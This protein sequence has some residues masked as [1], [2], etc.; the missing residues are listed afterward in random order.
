MSSFTSEIKVGLLTVISLALM[1]WF[2]LS[3]R[4]APFGL[5][6]SYSIYAT[7]PSAEGIQFG[8]AVTMA[9]VKVGRVGTIELTGAGQARI[10]LELDK[11]VA[12]PKDSKMTVKSMGLL[13]DRS[14]H[15]LPGQATD[16]VA[17]GGEIPYTAGETDID[18]LTKKLAGVADEV[19]GITSDLKTISGS[20][21]DTITGGTMTSSL[22]AILKNMEA[23]SASVKNVSGSSQQDIDAIL[24]NIETLTANMNE[25]VKVSK[26]VVSDSGEQ[27]Q[28]KI[29]SVD[30]IVAEVNDVVK[31]LNTIVQKVEKGE[32]TVGALLT[33]ASTY[34]T[35]KETVNTA[36]DMVDKV[37]RFETTVELRGDY[38][39]AAAPA[40]QGQMK[41]TLGVT[42]ATRKDYY[43]L[44]EITSDPV[45]DFTFEETSYYDNTGLQ[46]GTIKKQ[47]FTDAYQYTFQFAKRFQDLVLRIGIKENHGAVGAD[48]F[49]WKDR[50]AFSADLYDFT[51]RDLIN[52]ELPNLELRSRVGL[53]NHMYL[54][55]GFDDVL[56][57][58]QAGGV[59]FYMGA[60]LSFQDADL[61]Y[62][63][64]VLPTP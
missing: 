4:D 50:I 20:L 29:K 18:Q 10:S 63:L 24:R 54:A 2:L 25:L 37:N 33:D 32:G 61:K 44:L 39:M 17:I 41:N 6:Q 8:S 12:L 14:V 40:L 62:L 47:V 59:N 48:Y 34:D 3:T 36:A 26:G 1:T 51:T 35:L 15:L 60:G 55:V 23:V 28:D 45:M 19:Q 38:Y 13:G 64:S 22:E 42:L 52:P 21:K 49:L 16:L 56:N 9:G 27:V 31:N 7:V 30:Q 57:R 46:T 43:Y 5:G 58:A 53:Y 11:V